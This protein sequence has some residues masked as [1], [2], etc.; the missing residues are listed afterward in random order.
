TQPA[1]PTQPEN[2]QNVTTTPTEIQKP[3]V[4][5]PAVTQPETNTTGEEKPNTFPWIA[6]G[7]GAAVLLAAGVVAVIWLRLRKKH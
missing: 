2:E 6:V 5:E 1:E 4:T 3:A 7:I